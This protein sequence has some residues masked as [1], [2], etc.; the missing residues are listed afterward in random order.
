MLV[1]RGLVLQVV[2]QGLGPMTPSMRSGPIHEAWILPVDTALGRFTEELTHTT[3]LRGVVPSTGHGWPRGWHLDLPNHVKLPTQGYGVLHITHKRFNGVRPVAPVNAPA[4]KSAVRG[5]DQGRGR[6][7]GRVAPNRDGAPV[8]DAPRNEAHPAHHEEVEKNVE[9]E[10]EENVGQEEEVQVETIA[11]QSPTNPPIAINVPKEGGT[12]GNDAIFRPLLVHVMIG[13]QHEM[14][15][16]FLKLKPP[17]FHG[18]ESATRGRHPQPVLVV[19]GLHLKPSPELIPKI[20]LRVDPRQDLWTV[21]SSLVV[22]IKE[23]QD[24]DPILLELKGAFHQQRVEVQILS[25]QIT[26]RSVPNTQFSSISV[27][28]PPRRANARN[29]NARNANAYPPIP[30]QEV[31]NTEFRN[32]IQ[33]LAQSVANQNNLRV[34]VPIDTNVGSSAARVRDFV[35]MN[36][37]D[38][39]GS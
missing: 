34:L 20:W 7:R 39:L 3:H 1:G 29:A 8:G 35:R 31:L 17:V 15:T 13:N 33:M 27:I 12:V 24:S 11:T 14:L 25:I 30:D 37:P 36:L 4:K 21:E 5:R 10:E 22:E 32:A 18:S 9:V 6:G 28:M 26:L 16:K 19:P 23:K 2:I 38:F